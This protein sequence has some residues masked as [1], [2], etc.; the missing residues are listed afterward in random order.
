MERAWG[1]MSINQADGP[2]EKPW[3]AKKHAG[4]RQHFPSPRL[5]GN[6][7]CAQHTEGLRL[8]SRP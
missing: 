3:A 1:H 4:V 6:H 2:M 8:R 5:P 7:G